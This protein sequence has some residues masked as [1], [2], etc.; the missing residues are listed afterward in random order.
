MTIIKLEEFELGIELLLF[1]FISDYC[2]VIFENSNGYILKL[3]EF[4]IKSNFKFN[5]LN[6]E[7]RELNNDYDDKY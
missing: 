1:E 5:L 6:I 4:N 2:I 7:N 3:P